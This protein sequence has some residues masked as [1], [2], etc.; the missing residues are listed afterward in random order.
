MNSYAFLYFY[1]LFNFCSNFHDSCDSSWRWNVINFWCEILFRNKV[2]R[3]VQI[4][5]EVPNEKMWV[6]HCEFHWKWQLR[7][8]QGN[9]TTSPISRNSSSNEPKEI[10]IRFFGVKFFFNGVLKKSKS[11]TVNIL[12][13][14]QKQN[15]T[16]SSNVPLNKETF[17]IQNLHFSLWIPLKG[18]ITKTL[19]QFYSNFHQRLILVETK[20]FFN[21]VLK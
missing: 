19:S 8:T 15:N 3:V 2:K 5:W 14:I 7:L 21:G 16:S 18:T 13:F 17:L 9:S 10:H 4:N 1:L 6:I 20:C 12:H 11:S